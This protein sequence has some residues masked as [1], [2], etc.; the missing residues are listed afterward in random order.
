M[1][2][3][4]L[5]LDIGTTSVKTSLYSCELK[6]LSCIT[7]E[8]A[9]DSY[10]SRVEV[11]I[12]RYLYAIESSIAKLKGRE[13]IAAIGITTQGETLIPVSLDGT[14]LSKAI[15]WLDNRAGSQAEKLKKLLSENLFYE[16]TG[17]PEIGDALPLA[18]L[19]WFLEEMP[20]LYEKSHKF[21]LLED[22][23]IFWLTGRFVTEKSLQT[24]TGWF[25]IRKDTY[26]PTALAAAGIEKDRLPELLECGQPVGMLLTERAVQL[27]LPPTALIITGAMDQTAA[28]LAA[29]GVQQG[30]ITETTGTALVMAACTE[31]PFFSSDKRITIYRHA[32]AGKYLY[33]PISNTAGMSL[34]WF[35]KEFC[36]DFA[37]NERY[38]KMDL[39]AASVPCGCQGLLFLPYLSGSV[40]PDFLPSAT[41]VFYGATLSSTRAHFI[42][43]IMEGIAYQT[44]DFLDLLASLGYKSHTI[45][46]L[47]GGAGSS[48]WMQM[49]ADICERSFLVP[50]CAQASSTGAALLAAQGAKLVA[51]DYYPPLINSNIYQ[52]QPSAFK[53]Y[54]N[55]RKSFHNVY[56][57]MRPLYEREAANETE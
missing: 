10:G 31:N 9:L 19:L 30:I 41:G 15:V 8:Y 4:I 43:A 48:L 37:E 13:T 25:D 32:I 26:W 21:L 44:A 29:G 40:D 38:E 42:R 56:Q 20:E 14:P 54:R 7:T 57:A 23:I 34:K 51:T 53:A 24:S 11:P 28:A 22:Y 39:L 33:L 49:K 50:K 5:T 36:N 3:T 12:E 1:S 17:L 2:L 55:Q 47:G 27:D 6:L 45:F 18:K 16:T 35:G 52:P 46:S